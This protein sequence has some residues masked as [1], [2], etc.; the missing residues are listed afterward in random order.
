MSRKLRKRG[1][2]VVVLALALVLAAPA[3]AAGL[4]GWAEAPTLLHSAWQWLDSLLPGPGAGGVRA[5]APAV[6]PVV[7][8]FHENSGAGVDPNGAV[9]PSGTSPVCKINCE[10]GAGVDPNG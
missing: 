6:S 7:R 9:A 8:P 1:F 4:P 2:A 3:H 10:G 5:K